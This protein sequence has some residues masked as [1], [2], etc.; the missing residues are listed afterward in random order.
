MKFEKLKTE[1]VKTA[2]RETKMERLNDESLKSVAGGVYCTH[3][4]PYS[5]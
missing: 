4:H 5:A 1:A 3:C 2:K